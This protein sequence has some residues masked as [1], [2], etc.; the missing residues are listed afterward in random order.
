MKQT[1]DV[2]VIIFS[3]YLIPKKDT[4]K[5]FAALQEARFE[6]KIPVFF[7]RHG[8]SRATMART[9]SSYQ[10]IFVSWLNLDGGRENTRSLVL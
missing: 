2:A 9:D 6:Q 5:N 10:R 4:R 3:G 1:S 7:I 8:R